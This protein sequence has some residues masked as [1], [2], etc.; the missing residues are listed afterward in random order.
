MAK[1]K[2][3]AE[4]V[5]VAYAVAV[6]AVRDC[7]AALR[8]GGHC[9]HEEP[10]KEKPSCLGNL[11]ACP[12]GPDGEMPR[13]REFYE[14]MCDNCKS[15]LEMIDER[16]AARITLGSAKRAVEVVGKRLTAEAVRG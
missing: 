8:S 7:D 13:W 3:S 10:W 4:E 9:P 12:Q 6:L 11:F 1:S 16:R 14:K 15:R 5:C 2:R